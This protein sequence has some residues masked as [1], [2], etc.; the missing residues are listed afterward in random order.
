[1]CL[2]RREQAFGFDGVISLGSALLS[3]ERSGEMIQGQ[4]IVCGWESEVVLY[5]P[6]ECLLPA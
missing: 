5:S 6:S 2:Q 4:L 1:M 3:E